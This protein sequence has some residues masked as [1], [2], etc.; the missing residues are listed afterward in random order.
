MQREGKIRHIGVSETSLAE[1]ERAKTLA[2]IVSVQNIYNVQNRGA[3][4][5]LQACERDG[6]AFLPWFPL[7]GRGKPRHAALA[8]IA[9]AHE[10]TPVQ[11]ALAWLLARS[12]AIVPIPGTSS[13]AHFDENLAAADLQL[14]PAELAELT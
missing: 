11:V 2:P 13:I 4:A 7:G 14:S 10:V 9:A 12:P 3:E 6:T 1:Y 5:V 8:R